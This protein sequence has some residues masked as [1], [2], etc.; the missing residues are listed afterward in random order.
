M[1]F[2]RITLV[3]LIAVFAIGLLAPVAALATGPSAGDQQYVDPLSGNSGS[4]SSSSSG[5]SGSSGSSSSGSSS[6][7][8]SSSG[9]VSSSTGSTGTVSSGSTAATTSTAAST[10]TLPYTGFNSYLAVAVG[11]G[12]V[13]AGFVLR[14]RIQT[15]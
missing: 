4:G 1:T 13:G 15:H 6:S 10:G 14:R 3:S 7:Q 2:R 11:V 12:L 5:S 9:S 8:S